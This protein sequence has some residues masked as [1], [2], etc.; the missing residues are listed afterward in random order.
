MNPIDARGLTACMCKVTLAAG[1][2]TTLSNTGSVTMAV[3]GKM[4]VNS[5]L[6]NTATPTTDYGTGATFLPVKTNKGSVFVVG[7][8]AAGT[9]KVIQGEV[10]DLDPAGGTF[11]NAP[12]FPMLPDD[13]C[14]IGYIIVKAGATASSAGWYF[15]VGNLATP[16]TGITLTFVDVCTLPNRPQIS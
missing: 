16:T 6:S 7:M 5:A 9:L 12:E 11:V 4:Y 14:P 8:L 1:T 10:T 2:T 15:G 13:V 3:N